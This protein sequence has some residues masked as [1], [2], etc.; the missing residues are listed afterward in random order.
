MKVA[1]GKRG[2]NHRSALT[3]QSHQKRNVGTFNF[4]LIAG[5]VSPPPLNNEIPADLLSSVGRKRESFSTSQTSL[6]RINENEHF[7]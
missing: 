6:M 3:F 1:E 2:I 5:A 7:L 4:V